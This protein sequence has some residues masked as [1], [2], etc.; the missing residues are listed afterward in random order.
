MEID[1]F[2]FVAFFVVLGCLLA[3]VQIVWAVAE[4]IISVF[5]PE[6]SLQVF[7]SAGEYMLTDYLTEKTG[8]EFSECSESGASKAESGHGISYWIDK[9]QSDWSLTLSGTYIEA[10]RY[11]NA[12]DD[13]IT[14][15]Q[16]V[17]NAHELA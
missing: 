13:L 12:L 4:K 11:F 15:I 17:E 14:H 10:V 6:S 9:R 3:A 8:L 5:F 1:S 2:N 7:L 16:K